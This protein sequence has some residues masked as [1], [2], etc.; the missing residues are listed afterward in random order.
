MIELGAVLVK[1]S[2]SIAKFREKVYHLSRKLNF[3]DVASARFGAI[4][5]ELCRLLST[6]SNGLFVEIFLSKKVEGITIVYK[7]HS[8]D[9]SRDILIDS[10][11]YF[12][13][14]RIINGELITLELEIDY[15]SLNL[16]S[17]LIIELTEIILKKNREELIG[18]VQ[19]KNE[20]LTLI[21]KSLEKFVPADFLKFLGKGSISDFKLGDAL[22]TDFTILFT[23]MRSFSSISENMTPNELLEFMNKYLD[24]VVPIISENNG[25]IITYIGDAIMCA[26]PGGSVDAAN[27]SIEMI[28]KVN[29]YNLSLVKTLGRKV[30]IGVGINKGKTVIGIL[31]NELRMEPAI[32]S[33]VVNLSARLEALTKGYDADIIISD[34]VYKDLKGHELLSQIRQIDCV[35]V[36]GRVTP[37]KIYEVVISNSDTKIVNKRNYENALNLYFDKK[38]I[39]S[40]KALAELE[41]GED[42]AVEILSK[43]CKE[44]VVFDENGFPVGEDIPNGWTPINS[45]KT[46][47]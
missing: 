25:F 33:D 38:I 46:K 15:N 18:E 9:V 29:E 31:G 4:F 19:E 40:Y 1:N 41:P 42:K 21:N 44:V 34:S 35:Q 36:V 12:V 7:L 45:I 26:F 28:K 37:E 32:M 24:V 39:E 22:E 2:Y 27:C 30:R 14:S 11:D 47:L 8:T 10:L 23:D 13:S 17:S 20:E 3:S 5:S 6:N 43:R 16:S